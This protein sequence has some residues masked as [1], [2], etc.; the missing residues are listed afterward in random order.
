MNDEQKQLLQA[1]EKAADLAY[2]PY[3]KF[4][5]GAAV[6]TAGGIYIGA[7]IE[8]AS[9]NL[10]TCAE[11]VALAQALMNGQNEIIG[12]A[13]HC[14]D[15][16]QENSGSSSEHDCMPCGACRQWMAELAPDAW[17]ITNSSENI[18]YLDNL[19]PNAFQLQK[20][21]G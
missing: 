9:T 17:L 2:A 20:N 12:I 18:Y 15:T 19:L 10:G 1:A 14:V 8:T 5:V 16:P 3:S 6:L 11:R 7:N 4:Q 21:D 13:V